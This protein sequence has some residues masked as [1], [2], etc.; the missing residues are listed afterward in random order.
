MEQHREIFTAWANQHLQT[1]I[2]DIVT[3]FSDLVLVEILQSISET[4]L[5]RISE[6]RTPFVQMENYNICFEF[7]KEHYNLRI[8]STSPSQLMEGDEKSIL[9][10]MWNLINY[11]IRNESLHLG[12]VH[13]HIQ[14]RQ[15]LISELQQ[16]FETTV[17]PIQSPEIGRRLQRARQELG[18]LSAFSQLQQ[19]GCESLEDEPEELP[20][21]SPFES[22]FDAPV[23]TEALGETVD[24]LISGDEAE[25]IAIEAP[26]EDSPLR[27]WE[28][29]HEAELAARAQQSEELHQAALQR[30]M[31][32]YQAFESNREEQKQKA[33]ALNRQAEAAMKEGL[34]LAA[35]HPWEQACSLVNFQR[36]HPGDISRFRQTMLRLKNNPPTPK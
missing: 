1:P 2:T 4:T 10:L 31:E 30:A 26:D 27:A 14:E 20:A 25:A 12:D 15:S 3:D 6:D 35:G 18:T 24:D 9:G 36:A 8:I 19:Q 29:A 7:M 32:E 13:T 17:D 28:H 11:L 16:Q 33:M 5:Q 21:S 34:Q 22:P 23:S